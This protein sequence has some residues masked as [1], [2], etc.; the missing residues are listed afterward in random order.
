MNTPPH[1]PAIKHVVIIGGGIAGLSAAWYLQQ[2]AAIRGV[3]LRF[4]V[5]EQSTVWGGKIY[6][7]QVEGF[8]NA[9]FVL[10]AGADAFLTRKPWALAL[11]RELGLEARIQGVNQDHSRTFVVHRGKLVPLPSGLQLLVPTR[12]WPF[13]RS[14]L[15]SFWGKLRVGME[16]LIRPRRN[17]ADE[18]LA[19]FVRRRL[20]PEAL[21]KLAEPLLAGVYNAEPERQSILA[22]FPQFPALEK[23]YGSLI[24]GTRATRRKREP[25][26]DAPP[27]I[28]FQSG[29]HELITALVTQLKGDL[30]LNV[31]VRAVRDIMRREGGYTVTM[32]DDTQLE[33]ESVI[34]ATP[35]NISAALVRDSVPEAAAQLGAIRYASISSMYL[36]FLRSEVPHPLDGFGVVI[37]GSE[38]RRIDGMTWTSSKW[39]QR[40]PSGYVLLRVFF[41]GPYTRDMMELDDDARSAIIRGELR[42]LLGI[43]AAP[44][45]QRVYRWQNGYPQYDVGHL[46]RVAAIESALPPGLYVAG[47]SYRGV[48]VPDCIKQGQAV[49]QQVIVNL[50]EKIIVEERLR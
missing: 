13:L 24:R 33:A 37:P 7:E 23:Q 8:G 11:A 28:S 15:L 47:S 1:N 26:N 4:T 14:P 32:N 9:P 22:T 49:A 36:G 16:M 46:D 10:E 2:G 35:A 27:F 31:T 19:N 5:L 42:S 18:S 30:R 50:F 3:E 20:G 43:A 45:F 39:N 17:A 34:L 44:T 12:L 25:N 6:T 41:G 38:R 21:D 40:A 29:A 48:G